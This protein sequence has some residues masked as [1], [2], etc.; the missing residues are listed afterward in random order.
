M[1][2]ASVCLGL[3]SIVSADA[4]LRISAGSMSKFTKWRHQE[5]KIRPS[6]AWR[7]AL[8]IR[9]NFVVVWPVHSEHGESTPGSLDVLRTQVAAPSGTKLPLPRR[10]VPLPEMAWSTR[11]NSGGDFIPVAS[12]CQVK[13]KPLHLCMGIPLVENTLLEDDSFQTG[14]PIH[15]AEHF[16]NQRE[17][18]QQ[19]SRSTHIPRTS[20]E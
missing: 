20:P 1:H 14:L 9:H 15:L 10:N 17:I 11:I 16:R 4:S 7:V 2:T 13:K 5:S 18:P 8:R 3:G 12:C 6:L 19:N